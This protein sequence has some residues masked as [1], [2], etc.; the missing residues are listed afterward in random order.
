MD[1][2]TAIFNIGSTIIDKIW[3]DKD[4]ADAAKLEMFKL[5]QQG[6]FAE[7]Q[8]GF[9]LMLENIKVN[10]NEAMHS[11]IFVAGWRPFIGWTCGV[12][13]AYNYIAMPFIVWVTK[14][15]YPEA[16]TMPALDMTELMVLLGGML[17]IAGLRSREITQGKR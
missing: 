15:F 10:A 4:K 8:N 16:P 5:Q 2:L 3:P 6:A 9:N 14:C 17:G 1:P 11:S 12:A 7:I 13:L